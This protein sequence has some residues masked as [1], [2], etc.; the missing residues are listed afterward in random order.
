[1]DTTMGMTREK[2]EA[3]VNRLGLTGQARAQKINELMGNTASRFEGTEEKK[4]QPKKKGSILKD[5]GTAMT[6]NQFGMGGAAMS[7]A[8]PT[9]QIKKE[10]QQSIDEIADATGLERDRGLLKGAGTIHSED[11]AQDLKD[12]GVSVSDEYKAKHPEVYDENYGKSDKFQV[13][14]NEIKKFNSGSSKGTSYASADDTKDYFDKNEKIANDMENRILSGIKSRS[15]G[16]WEEYKKTKEKLTDAYSNIDK[17]YINELPTFMYQRYKNG[18]FGNLDDPE[19][20]KNAQLRL[21]HFMINGLG[22]AL[23]NASNVIKGKELE[24]S[25]YEKYQNSNLEQGLANRWKVN[26]AETEEVIKLANKEADNEQ[27]ARLTVQQL[28]RD[29]TMKAAWNALDQNQKLWSVNVAREIGKMVGD[30]DI[31]ELANFITGSA[32]SGDI[33]KEEVIAVGVA[34]LVSKSPELFEQL[35]EGGIKNAV[36]SL[37]GFGK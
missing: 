27:D 10:E 4:E 25:D 17:K 28:T 33:S 34:S 23:S 31:S 26:N 6:N 24:Q 21:A 19:S 3:E 13:G 9:M 37:L 20:K 11:I 1:M 14:D 32:I 36:K 18:E 5:I 29:N 16:N 12:R 22:T 7:N 8:Q 30:M 15:D 35:P 2:A